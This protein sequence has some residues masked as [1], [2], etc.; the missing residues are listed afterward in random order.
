MTGANVDTLRSFSSDR[1]CDGRDAHFDRLAM[2][3]PA[4]RSDSHARHQA[5]SRKP[6]RFVAGLKRRASAFDGKT[7]EEVA[8][9]ILE[10]DNR[11]RAA[12]AAFE[13]HQAR[14]NEASRAIG[15]AKAK[16]D[17]AGAAGADGRS[18]R[19]EGRDPE[20]RGRAARA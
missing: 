5:N 11:W 19:P 15:Q 7:P 10:L 9:D 17:E 4:R 2:P 6:G 1:M 14:Q 12:K 20:G 13:Q 3:L 8:A 18:R 16:K